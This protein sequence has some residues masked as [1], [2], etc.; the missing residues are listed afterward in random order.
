MQKDQVYTRTSEKSVVEF[1][2]SLGE[3]TKKSGFVI[4]NQSTMD[5]AHSF[6]RHGAEVAEGFDLHMIQICKPEKAAKSLSANPE[7]AI[8][9][10]KF[11]MAFSKEGKTQIRFLSFSE[12]NIRGVV[13]DDVFPA[14]LAETYNKIHEMIDEAK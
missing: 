9:M 14:S 5:M 2:A 7:R 10:P 8:L 11:I 6:G 4:H 3:V 12:D 13:D 1:V